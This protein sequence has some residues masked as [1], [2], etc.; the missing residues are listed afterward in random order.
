VTPASRTSGGR[1]TK[2]ELAQAIQDVDGNMSKL[3]KVLGVSRQTLYRWC[4]EL[5]ISVEPSGD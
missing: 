2:E 3:A 4:R 5:E 1:P